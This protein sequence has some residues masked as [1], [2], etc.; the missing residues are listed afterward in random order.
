MIVELT[1]EEIHDIKKAL[2]YR[3][4]EIENLKESDGTDKAYA[5]KLELIDNKLSD[6]ILHS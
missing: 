1:Y 2:I 6:I 5:D 4:N 3:M